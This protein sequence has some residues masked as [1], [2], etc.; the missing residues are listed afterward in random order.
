MCLVL[1]LFL[2]AG[3]GA[4]EGGYQP[5][6]TRGFQGHSLGLD[7]PGGAWDFVVPVRTDEPR[8]VFDLAAVECARWLDSDDPSETWPLNGAHGAVPPTPPT[9]RVVP[10]RSGWMTVAVRAWAPGEQAEQAGSP[11]VVPVRVTLTDVVLADGRV[12]GTL[13]PIDTYSGLVPP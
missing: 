9:V 3:L 2:C 7:A 10:V 12:V 4:A 11:A 1:F 8:Q 5:V 6:T 13:P